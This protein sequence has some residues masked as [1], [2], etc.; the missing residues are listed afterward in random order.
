MCA[1]AQIREFALTIERD[2]TVLETLKEFELVFVA[3]FREIGNGISPRH[4]HALIRN[5]TLDE[6]HHL[7]FDLRQ[8]CNAELYV[9]R[10][11]NV[12]IETG[13]NRRPDAE[14]H[15]RIHVLQSFRHQVSR[16]MP[17]DLLAFVVIEGDDA[18]R[19]VHRDRTRKVIRLVV[20]VDTNSHA[21]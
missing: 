17:E 15:T 6:F 10:Q 11:I 4:L 8:V 14:L 19:S 9:S 16:G 7:R 20:D 3:L 2:L 18:D 13:F 1:T 21:C 5:I 12:I